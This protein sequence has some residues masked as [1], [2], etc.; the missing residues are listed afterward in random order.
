VK[1]YQLIATMVTVAAL[2]GCAATNHRNQM[3]DFE[4]HWRMGDYSS[5]AAMF[6]D[7]EDGPESLEE[8]SLFELLHYAEAA[9]L[10]GDL[11]AA[12]AAYDETEDYFKRFDEE[13]LA[14]NAAETVGSILVN[15]SVTA[16]EGHLYEAILSNSYKAISFLASGKSDMARVELNRA[17]DR[18]RRAVEYF[19]K[20]I[21]EERKAL[22]E[23]DDEQEK[24]QAVVKTLESDKLSESLESEY[25]SLSQ[26]SVYPS[27]INPFATYLHAIYF[28][29]SDVAGD[30]QRAI[31]SLQRVAGMTENPY[32][33]QDLAIAESRMEG[34]S[35]ADDRGRVWVIYE[36]GMGPSL[37]EKRIDVPIFLVS[38]SSGVSYT[39][40]A[41]PDMDRGVTAAQRLVVSYVD[42]DGA[43]RK[44]E[45]SPLADMER[46]ARTE[47]KEKFDGILARSIASAAVKAAVQAAATE[48]FGA[49]GQLA[50][51]VLT[52]AT[53][54]ADLR[55]WRAIP[56]R[57]DAVAME[58]PSGSNVIEIRADNGAF[59]REIELPEWENTLVYIKQPSA[60]SRPA[61]MVVD[62]EGEQVQ[63]GAGY[64]A[65]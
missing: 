58:R 19:S 6:A 53:T 44:L 16:Y 36:N 65:P 26:W 20:L 22:E 15:D 55:S 45:S 49:W 32:V 41:L 14:D 61:V 52:A 2:T 7:S 40:I 39:G 27:F 51:G 43:P 12:V 9:R 35:G 1:F 23:S 29:S 17:D 28:L 48:E 21:E 31:D 25:G 37:E 57:W 33:E 63:V 4:T 42:Q 24:A 10:S 50:G 38:Q 30:T 59:M 60:T 62:M 64:A 18:T 3:E 5:A 8:L 54:Q 13:N 11:Q 56:S 34:P 47:F 46:V